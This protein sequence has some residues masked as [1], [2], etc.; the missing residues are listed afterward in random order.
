MADTP[1]TNEVIV[2]HEHTGAEEVT[3]VEV[4]SEDERGHVVGEVIEAILDP[5][6]GTEADPA[7]GTVHEEVIIIEEHVGEAGHGEVITET[8][9][10]VPGV[11]DRDLSSVRLIIAG[12]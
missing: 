3:I 10:E 8:I 9:V 1:V 11:E 6:H 7:H 2:V 5:A 12:G 4:I